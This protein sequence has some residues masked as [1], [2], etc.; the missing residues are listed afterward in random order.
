P[1]VQIHYD[2]VENQ[3]LTSCFKIH[4]VEIADSAEIKHHCTSLRKH[5]NECY[6][7]LVYNPEGTMEILDVD[8]Q[9]NAY[10]SGVYAIA[11][12]FEFLCGGNPIYK[13]E[14]KK[15]RRHLIRCFNRRKFT[16]FP[17]KT[18]ACVVDQEPEVHQANFMPL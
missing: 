1:S 14:Q 7:E 11:N 12:A 10:D 13:Y 17:K 18:D 3:W 16:A 6:S 4:H 5:I 2:S 15:M 8:E 9:A